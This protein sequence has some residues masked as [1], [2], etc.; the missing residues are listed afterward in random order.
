MVIYNKS[1]LA[2]VKGKYFADT[3]GDADICA[4]ADCPY[5][6]GNEDKGVAPAS[7]EMHVENVDYE[8]L[9]KYMK[10][11]GDVRFRNLIPPLREKG[12]WDFPYDIFISVMLAEKDVFMINT[13]RMVGVDALDESSVTRAII[14]ARKENFKLFEIM[15]NHFPGFKKCEDTRYSS[16]TRNSRKPSYSRRICA[17]SRRPCRAQEI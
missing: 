1:G 16:R 5:L 17:D 15:K 10:Q 4:F 13:N 12:I 2:L 9:S 3:T 7:L 11:T 14:D 6:V 8:E